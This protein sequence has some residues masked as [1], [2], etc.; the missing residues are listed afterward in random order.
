MKPAY[1]IVTPFWIK[2]SLD[3]SSF[4]DELQVRSNEILNMHR[5]E[6]NHYLDVLSLCLSKNS[7]HL[8]LDRFRYMR[9]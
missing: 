9:R 5:L 7:I 1:R 2:E 6:G 3:G 4:E 8:H